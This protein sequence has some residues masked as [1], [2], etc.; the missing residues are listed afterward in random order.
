MD[1]TNITGVLTGEPN[2]QGQGNTLKRY[3]EGVLNIE[4]QTGIG[5]SGI[6]LF[7]AS[8]CETSSV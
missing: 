8:P 7:E 4:H 5:E 3:D 2:E 6:N 1:H